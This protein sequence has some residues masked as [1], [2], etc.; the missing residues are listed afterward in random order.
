M[1]RRSSTAFAPISPPPS[2]SGTRSTS[3][4]SRR[5]GRTRTARAGGC[6]CSRT[7]AGPRA[8]STDSRAFRAGCG[9]T[10]SSSSSWAGCANSTATVPPLG[11]SAST[12]SISTASTRRLRRCSAISAPSIPQRP[13]APASDTPASSSLAPMCT[14]MATRPASG[15]RDRAK[16]T[17]S[18]SCW[19]CG[20]ARRSTC[21]ATGTSPRT[22]TSSPNR[23]RAWSETRSSTI[24]RCSATAPSRGTCATRI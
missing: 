1:G 8:R 24:A 21:A 7:R 14:A 22:S 13:R 3:S 2:W 5:T 23:M 11:A 15:C 18:H 12:G 9:G 6:A 16:R 10:T 20:G 17:S 4:P 19:T